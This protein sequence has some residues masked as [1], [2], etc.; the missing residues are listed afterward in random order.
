MRTNRKSPGTCP[1]KWV[2]KDTGR[3]PS[4]FIR[5][6]HQRVLDQCSVFF[7][8]PLASFLPSFFLKTIHSFLAVTCNSDFNFSHRQRMHNAPDSCRRTM[9][10]GDNTLLLARLCGAYRLSMAPPKKRARNGDAA[11]SSLASDFRAL[12]LVKTYVYCTRA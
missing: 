11:P 9:N 8:H 3:I 10:G 1:P 6:I 4:A 2:R 7:S 5:P 12:W